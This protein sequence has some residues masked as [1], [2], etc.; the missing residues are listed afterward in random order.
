[1]IALMSKMIGSIHRTGIRFLQL[2]YQSPELQELHFKQSKDSRV[3][4][5]YN[6]DDLSVI[7]VHD[8]SQRKFLVVPCTN[9]KYS[10]GLNEHVHRLHLNTLKSERKVDVQALMTVKEKMLRLIEEERY[11][12]LGYKNTIKKRGIPKASMSQNEVD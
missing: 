4:F 12:T 2:Y 11:K 1:M 3:E 5:H 8:K 6:P 10:K 7:Y 9:Q